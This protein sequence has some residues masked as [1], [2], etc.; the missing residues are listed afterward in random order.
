MSEIE[1]PGVA[2]APLT[3]ARIAWPTRAKSRARDA[4]TLPR[5]LLLLIAAA[6]A[7]GYAW[8][9]DTAGLENFYTAGVHSMAGSWHAF[10]YDAF[11]PNATIT[12]DKLPGAFWIQALSVRCFGYS[13]WAMVLPQV[14]ESTLTVLVLYRAVRR[15]AG[16]AAALTASAIL[17][18]SPVV[19]SSTRGNLA[20]PMY[21]LCIVLAADATLRAVTTGRSR[22][23]YAAAGWVALGFQAKMTEAWLVLPILALALLAAAPAGRW[24]VVLR[25]GLGMLLAAALS[26]VWMLCFTF[27]PAADRPYADGSKNNSI[28]QQVFDY[29]G[30]LRFSANPGASFR[31]LAAPSPLAEDIAVDNLAE[32]GEILPATEI[33]KASWD[34]LLSGALAP[35]C[36]WF[37]L[38]AVGG[39]AASFVS[40]RGGG[41]GDPARAATVLWS[42]WL[43][44]YGAAFSSA[45]FIQGYYLATLVPA[46][47]ALAGTGVWV[48]WRAARSGSRRAGVGLGALFLGQ[49]AWSAWLLHGTYILL[50]WLILAAAVV[51]AAVAGLAAVRARAARTTPGAAEAAAPEISGDDAVAAAP[52]GPAAGARPGRLLRRA[53]ATVGAAAMIAGPLAGITWLEVRAG[54]PFDAALSTQGTAAQPTAAVKAAWS[55]VEGAYGGSVHAQYTSGQWAQFNSDGTTREAQLTAG[56]SEILVFSSAEA[57]DYIAYGYTSIVPVGGFSGDAP[58]PGVAQIQQLIK[59][60]TISLAVLPGADVLTANDPRVQAVE[61]MCKPY[62]DTPASAPYVVYICNGEPGD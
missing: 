7:T 48:L 23:W 56:G 4:A 20:E 51:A 11:D 26:L 17:A 45:H 28:F 61:L 38:L 14:L 13:V 32:S 31:P 47:A 57:A 44:A 15:T 62:G 58:Y 46:I 50:S 2:E 39:A 53:V 33:T 42:G 52:A 55:E 8:S 59:A 54:G 43:L 1:L 24:R 36:D 27:T 19:V 25:A 41:R 18:A 12:L 9:I 22:S 5:I 37:L 40:R 60:G 30:T 16:T 29:N 35:D 10:F 3:P 21:L 49:A 6:A 34:R